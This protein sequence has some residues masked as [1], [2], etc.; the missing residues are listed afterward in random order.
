MALGLVSPVV[1]KFIRL[2]PSKSATSMTSVPGSVQYSFLLTQSTAS[3]S[4]E[5]RPSS[6]TTLTLR[7]LLTGA[8]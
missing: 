7:L 6:N 5:E 4:G 2:L 8:R 3:P 1:I